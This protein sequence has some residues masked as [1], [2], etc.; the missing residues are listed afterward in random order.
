MTAMRIK[1]ILEKLQSG[2]NYTNVKH[3]LRIPEGFS[4]YPY[5]PTEI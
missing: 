3:N 5:Y 1:G 2:T 4:H